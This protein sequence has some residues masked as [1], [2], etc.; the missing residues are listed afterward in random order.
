[1]ICFTFSSTAAMRSPCTFELN[2]SQT[3]YFATMEDRRHARPAGQG[4]PASLKTARLTSPLWRAYLCN[5]SHPERSES[6]PH[7]HLES[8]DR[9]LLRAPLPVQPDP[10][11]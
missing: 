10:V 5:R 1:M 4:R 9:M 2:G 3:L 6:S 8:P 7:L 11:S